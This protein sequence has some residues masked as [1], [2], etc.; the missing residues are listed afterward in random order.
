MKRAW[1]TLPTLSIRM[2]QLIA[3]A[4]FCAGPA[5]AD[6]PTQFDLICGVKTGSGTAAWSVRYRVDLTKDAFC[7]DGH[8]SA[9][10]RHDGQKLIYHCKAENGGGFCDPVPD[11]LGG[12]HIASDDLVIDLS[13]SSFQR[14]YSGFAGDRIGRPIGGDYSGKCTVSSFTGVGE[15]KQ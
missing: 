3:A 2:V 9:F 15:L 4:A 5:L 10:T 6:K 1:I 7:G 8:C 14:T 11:S 12:R 13:T